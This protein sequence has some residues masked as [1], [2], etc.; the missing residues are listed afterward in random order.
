LSFYI[1]Y[2]TNNFTV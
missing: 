2:P 1:F